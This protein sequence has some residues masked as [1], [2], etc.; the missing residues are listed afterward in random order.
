MGGNKTVMC[1]VT[2]HGKRSTWSERS[3]T[4]NGHSF[5]THLNMFAERNDLEI[6]V[7]VTFRFDC[8]I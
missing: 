5:D 8:C 1:Y 6:F 4:I 7:V 2:V 3:R